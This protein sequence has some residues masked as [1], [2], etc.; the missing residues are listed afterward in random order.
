M[1]GV[2]VII[3]L[4]LDII[5][6]RLTSRVRVYTPKGLGVRVITPKENI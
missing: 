1:L 5:P 2:R 3:P 6:K 4:G